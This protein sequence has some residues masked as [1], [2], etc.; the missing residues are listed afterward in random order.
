M[1]FDIL[2]PD[3]W[4]KAF[5][6]SLLSIMLGLV[7]HASLLLHCNSSITFLQYNFITLSYVLSSL[8][9]GFLSWE[10][11]ILSNVFCTSIEVIKLFY[12]SFYSCSVSQLLFGYT[13]ASL[14]V[15]DNSHLV[16][17]YNSFNV[18]LNLIADT[19]L[20]IFASIL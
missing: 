2:V 15:R 14:H 12:I 10:C 6:L 20:I 7:C 13:E 4:E 5:K 1:T 8:C 17:V 3:L 11:C 18:F 19:L 9:W 16:L